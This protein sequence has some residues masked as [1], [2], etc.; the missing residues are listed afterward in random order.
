MTIRDRVAD[1]RR[2]SRETRE[3]ACFSKSN[4]TETERARANIAGLGACATLSNTL[5]LASGLAMRRA[6]R[7][8]DRIRAN[9]AQIEPLRCGC[10]NRVEELC[11]VRDAAR[12]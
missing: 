9:L 2:A 10:H 7:C 1:D 12:G 5:E 8:L 6:Q 3:R 4:K 11:A